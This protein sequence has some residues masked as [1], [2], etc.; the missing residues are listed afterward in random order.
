MNSI[1]I[2]LFAFFYVGLVILTLRLF[3]NTDE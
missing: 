1:E 3:K 2:G